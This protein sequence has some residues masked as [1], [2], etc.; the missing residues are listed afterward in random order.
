VCIASYNSLN[1]PCPRQDGTQVGQ[2]LYLSSIKLHDFCLRD[3]TP[4]FCDKFI[5]AYERTF[6]QAA[7]RR[8]LPLMSNQQC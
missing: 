4:D 7:R 8:N 2:N 6:H 1:Y 3:K 5:I